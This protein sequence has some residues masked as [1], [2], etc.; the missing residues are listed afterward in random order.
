[1]TQWFV[2][3]DT[4]IKNRMC[5][6]TVFIMVLLL[7][8]VLSLIRLGIVFAV[9]NNASLT[10]RDDAGVA[11][12]RVFEFI[13]SDQSSSNALTFITDVSKM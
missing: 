9:N 7:G 6:V 11:L 3:Y 1:M 4:M 12:A 10:G 2:K 5:H 13:K 8:S